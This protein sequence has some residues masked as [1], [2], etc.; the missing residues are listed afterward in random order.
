MEI[1]FRTGKENHKLADLI[2]SKESIVKLVGWSSDDDVVIKNWKFIDYKRIPSQVKSNSINKWVQLNQVSFVDCTFKD[3]NFIGGVPMDGC[4]FKNC[5]F[6][7]CLLTNH[8]RWCNFNKCSFNFCIFAGYF[9]GSKFNANCKFEKVLLSCYGDIYS[10]LRKGAKCT[11]DEKIELLKYFYPIEAEV[12]NIYKVGDPYFVKRFNG[13]WN[14]KEMD[15]YEMYKIDNKNYFKDT[16]KKIE[17]DLTNYEPMIQ[18]VGKYA[19]LVNECKPCY[20]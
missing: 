5:T 1:R 11:K 7:N 10:T 8:I 14:K 6:E 2:S 20:I 15:K 19:P 3:I 16:V 17:F 12:F 18:I 9:H 13:D 4:S